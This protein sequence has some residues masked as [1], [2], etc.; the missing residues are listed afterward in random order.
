MSS[1]GFLAWSLVAALLPAIVQGGTPAKPAD[2]IHEWSARAQQLAGAAGMHPLRAPITLG[3]VHLAV[4]DAVNAIAGG[5]APYV[6]APPVT[7]PA[8]MEAAAVEAAYR[9]LAVELPS[10]LAA[11]DAAR[12]ASLA[13]MPEPDRSNGLAVGAAAAAAL[14][15]RRAHDGRNDVVPY[16]PGSG[17]GAW[18]PTPQGF[19]P[20]AG[21]FLARVAPFTMRSPSQFRPEGP[22][23]LR[24][25]K[26]AED[27]REVKSLGARQSPTR[28]P[29]QTATARFWE[30]LAGTVWPA[31]IR[32]MA[33]ERGLDMATAARF[34]AATFAAFAD[35]LVACWDAKYRFNFWR[36]LTAIR[37]GD[38][39]GNEHTEADPAWEPLSITPAFPEYASGHAC[40]TT[41]VVGVMEDFF[42]HDLRIP[43]RNVDSGEE[44]FYRRAR[45]VS[46][47]VVE[48]RMLLGVH[49][50]SA[51]EDG[52][53]IG[54]RIA[55]QIRTKL[56][57]P[58][59][60][61]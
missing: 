11:L 30:P 42:P 32:R 16:E 54:R 51:D 40:T 14:L 60:R 36:P 2:V 48:A 1:R 15:A 37:A 45:D 20:A 7:R 4:Y 26:Y 59:P 49:F 28:T 39:D 35:G 44:R 12:T 53:E 5:H 33:A 57:R 41:A 22:P 19:L 47:E 29:E 52:A 18:I 8:S 61:P 13:P 10:Q 3:L 9:V 34:E 27:Y 43:A 21:P 56:F 50:R 17:P 38:T 58:Q 25:R 6:S 23:P 31:S 55:R 46:D 24:S